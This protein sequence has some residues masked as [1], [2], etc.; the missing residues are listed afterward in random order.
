VLGP[1]TTDEA[2]AALAPRV[3]SYLPDEARAPAV[4]SPALGPSRL[5]RLEAPGDAPGLLLIGQRLGLR[6]PSLEPAVALLRDAWLEVGAPRSLAAAGCQGLDDA[7]AAV[8]PGR[9]PLLALRCPGVPVD[10]LAA[11]LDQAAGDLDR[12]R[13]T[14]LPVKT[15]RAIQERRSG[16]LLLALEEPA[17]QA[18]ALCDLERDG[19]RA[20]ALAGLPRAVAAVTPRE[21]QAAAAALL[22]PQALHA[23]VRAPAGSLLPGSTARPP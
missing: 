14:P 10:A 20:E 22:A 4:E 17:Q 11:L 2:V 8:L 18:R 13:R 12:L 7:D 19:G 6:Q 5:E 23:V 1:V 15:L 9:A 16:A 3:P 21:L